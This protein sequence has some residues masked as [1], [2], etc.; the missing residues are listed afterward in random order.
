[1]TVIVNLYM[2]VN[3]TVARRICITYTVPCIFCIPRQHLDN[4]LQL[5]ALIISNTAAQKALGNEDGW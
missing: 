1:M 2:F 4:G 5:E 3:C